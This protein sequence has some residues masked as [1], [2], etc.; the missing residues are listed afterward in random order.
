MRPDRAL[1]ELRGLLSYMTWL[2]S[3]AKGYTI[4]L[5]PDFFTALCAL[6]E[7]GED[8]PFTSDARSGFNRLGGH[9]FLV[10]PLA[11]RLHWTVRTDRRRRLQLPSAQ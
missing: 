5:S 7:A 11:Y 9:P 6:H 3:G 10:E 2:W 4:C 1:A 8:V